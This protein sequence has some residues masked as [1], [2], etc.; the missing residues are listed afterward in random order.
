MEK[1]V[2]TTEIEE[3]INLEK[4][5]LEAQDASFKEKLKAVKSAREEADRQSVAQKD[6]FDSMVE[7]RKKLQEIGNCSFFTL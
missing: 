3:K 2:D 4:K 7:Q 5:M 1:N 6:I